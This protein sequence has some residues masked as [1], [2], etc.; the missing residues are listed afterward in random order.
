MGHEGHARDVANRTPITISVMLATIMISLDTTIANV[1]LP[2]IQGSVSASADQITWV[3]TSYIVAS[4]IMTPL[5]GFLTERMGR[6]MVLI[7]SIIGFTA[8]SMLCGA[9]QN[10]IEIVLFRLLQ[11]L[12]GAALIPLSQAVLLDIN[13]PERHGQAMA[14]WGAGAVLGPLLGPG[15]GGWLTDNLD[16]RWVFFINLPIGIVALGGV[17]FFL[18]EKKNNEHRKFDTLG[19]LALAIAIGAFQLML[20]RGPSQ[21]WFGSR[22]IW[23][24]LIVAIIAL[25][26]FGAQLATAQKPFVA[27]ELLADGNFITCC[28]F[29]FFIGILLY[30]TL[31]LLP[32][33]AFT[34]LVSMPRGLGSFIAMFAVGQLMG[35]MNIKLLLAVGLSISALSLWQMSH[36]NLQM[37]TTLLVTSGFLSGVGTGLIFVP[38]STIA[39]AKVLPERRPEAAGLFTLIRNIGSAAGISI[40]QALFVSG[41]E[42]HHAVLVE[43]ARPD[44]P[45]Y[46]AYAPNTFSTEA[47]MAAFNGVIGRQAAMLSYLDD[48]RL[49]LVITIACAPLILLMR[50]PKPGA[51]AANVSDH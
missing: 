14:V 26:V 7:V 25:W 42:K 51:K 4:T 44:N 12:F 15:L 35:R 11:G 21:D 37:D 3:L 39:F 50:T 9:A 23:A 10:L 30:S 1:A 19:F 28:V 47:T 18:S 46:Q 29:G 45:L 20:D 13:P 5:T 48:F 33:V 40:M 36:Y 49:M 34:G 17:F 38:L 31:A 24:E 22:E 27:R 43:H 8:A 32:P 2:H 41:I 6:K 16:W